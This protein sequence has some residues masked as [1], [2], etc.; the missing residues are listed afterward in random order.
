[1]V[2]SHAPSDNRALAGRQAL[3]GPTWKALDGST[4]VR[5]RLAG[6]TLDAS[7]IPRLLRE[8]SAQAGNGR[9][10]K[11]TCVQRLFAH[12]GNAPVEGRDAAV[13]EVY[14][15]APCAFYGSKAHH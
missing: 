14:Y 9:M 12:G 7:A 2:A 8:A 10:T 15:S 5:K 13:S 11:V 1:V 4:V 3:C 6:A